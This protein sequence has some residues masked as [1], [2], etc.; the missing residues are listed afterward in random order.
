VNDYPKSLAL[1]NPVR[2]SSDALNP[3]GIILK[4]DP[5]AAVGPEG[6]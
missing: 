5:A 4:S 3:A 2:N 6:L 1:I